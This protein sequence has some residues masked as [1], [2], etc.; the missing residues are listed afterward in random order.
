MLLGF[1]LLLGVL[2][3][4]KGCSL[5]DNKKTSKVTAHV[6]DTVLLPCS[7]AAQQSPAS[8]PTWRKINKLTKDWDSVTLNQKRFQL[9]N[10]QVPGNL[11]LLI[12]H[13][14]VEDDGLYRCQIR[15]DYYTDINLSVQARK[16]EQTPSSE[17]LTG[18]KND[19]ET[20]GKEQET[21]DD[22]T[23]TT[24]VPTDTAQRPKVVSPEERTEYA[25]IKLNQ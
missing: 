23:Y 24:V 19:E 2:H 4:T 1:Y 9:S 18:Q 10:V 20:E 22:V 17:G 5:T 14:T 12:S 3:V 16:R 8:M 15:R 11:S 6:G 25:V 21:Q 7:C 13:L